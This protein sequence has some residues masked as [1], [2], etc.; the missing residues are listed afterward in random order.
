[1]LRYSMSRG[2]LCQC[3]LELN[4]NKL[5][6]LL[7]F[8]DILL[9]IM[10]R[11]KLKGKGNFKEFL[12]TRLPELFRELMSH[13]PAALDI[14]S[15]STPVSWHRGGFWYLLECFR[16]CCHMYWMYQRPL[17][18]INTRKLGVAHTFEIVTTSVKPCMVT[19][20]WTKYPT[21]QQ[22]SSWCKCMHLPLAHHDRT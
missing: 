21:P 13:H 20:C 11:R 22:R 1:M 16:G 18:C 2:V 12:G 6:F 3:D 15:C 9:Y 19:R 4:R 7:K 10:P 17:A 5:S 8:Y 14:R